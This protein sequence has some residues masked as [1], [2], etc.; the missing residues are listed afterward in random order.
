ML[1]CDP[2]SVGHF[3]VLSWMEYFAHTDTV[4]HHEIFEVPEQ[5]WEKSLPGLRP[6]IIN[7][8]E[9]SHISH[10]KI[11]A[12][13]IFSVTTL[14]SFIL[15]TPSFFLLIIFSDISAFQFFACEGMERPEEGRQSLERKKAE[16]RKR[17]LKFSEKS[18]IQLKEKSFCSESENSPWLSTQKE[19]W[20]WM[21]LLLT[22]VF[23]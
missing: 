18:I 9:T 10:T 23:N 21:L 19:P 5:E 13:V 12:G 16:A 22:V 17:C 4:I 7:L 6:V 20:S 14:A 11:K 15:F 2:R 8:V 1:Y 3:T